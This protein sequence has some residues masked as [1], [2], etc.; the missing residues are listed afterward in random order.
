MWWWGRGGGGGGRGATA[1]TRPG[2]TGTVR[3]A[4]RPHEPISPA[5]VLAIVTGEYT[6]VL[7]MAVVPVLFVLVVMSPVAIVSNRMNAG[8]VR[9]TCLH[10]RI[11]PGCGYSFAELPADDGGL[12]TCPECQSAWRLEPLT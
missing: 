4:R 7:M 2:S 8:L 11:C 9:A 1:R 10:D 12:T 6:V 5:A 3:R